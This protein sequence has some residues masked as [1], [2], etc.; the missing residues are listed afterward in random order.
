[1]VEVEAEDEREE[2][3]EMG[4]N[5]EITIQQVKNKK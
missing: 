1:M 4:N 3:L 5:N 2:R